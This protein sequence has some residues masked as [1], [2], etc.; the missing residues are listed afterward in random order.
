MIDNG[1]T[2]LAPTSDIKSGKRREGGVRRIC[3][4]KN[5]NHR[6]YHHHRQEKQTLYY[7]HSC[8]YQMK[9]K[10]ISKGLKITIRLS[11]DTGG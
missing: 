3:N 5:W 11:Q 2:L 4:H 10:E 7:M 8:L 9:P 1:V 6:Y